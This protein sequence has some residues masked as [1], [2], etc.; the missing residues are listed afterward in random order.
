MTLLAVAVACCVSVKGPSISSLAPPP[1]PFPNAN[2]LPFFRPAVQVRRE[3]GP[4]AV[5]ITPTRE[6]AQQSFTVM[7][8]LL[9]AFAWIVPGAI[10]GGEKKKSEKARLRK[11]INVL[12]A[13]PGRLRDHIE[14]TRTLDLKSIRWLVLDEADRY[15]SATRR[16]PGDG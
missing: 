1:P 5:I 11:G 6:L 2:H 12:I 7:Q 14:H 15:E 3:D 4:L 10:T 9:G 13:T 16:G 8:S